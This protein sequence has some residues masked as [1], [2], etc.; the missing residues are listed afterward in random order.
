ML[1]QNNTSR[2][3][4]GEH[5]LTTRLQPM[6]FSDI[7]DTTFSLYRN[8]FVLFL[9]VTT[10]YLVG[11]LGQLLLGNSFE[12][13]FSHS[14]LLGIAI[15]VLT[16]VFSIIGIG[17]IVVATSATYLGENI[18]IRSVLQRTIH[19][20]WYLVGCSFLWSLV[21]G[22][23]TITIIGIPF[24]I[25]FAV[26]WGFF[27]ATVILESSLVRDAFRRSSELVSGVWW[28]IFG[29]LLAIYLLSTALH[30]ILKFL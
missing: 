28:K 8:H 21:V 22:A 20:F 7:L 4:N 26:R 2:H 24:A 25:Y 10:V 30:A 13:F 29:M 17:G 14:F 27:V 16:G 19:K 12:S 11:E 15:V 23:L 6:G 18:T 1:E 5:T 9:G 3:Q